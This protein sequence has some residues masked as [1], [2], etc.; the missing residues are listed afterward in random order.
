MAVLRL[1]RG[2][3]KTAKGWR[4]RIRV[5]GQ[6]RYEK[7]FPFSTP[8]EDVIQ[9]AIEARA[10][11]REG[12]T[13]DLLLPVGGTLAGDIARYL[14]DFYKSRP[15][16]AER[17][18]HLALW[19]DELGAETWRKGIRREAVSRVL[20][21]WRAAGL[22]PETCNKRRTALLAMFNALDGRSAK[23][24][25]RDVAKFRVPPPLARGLD[26]RL[27]ARAFRKMSRCPTRARLKV[28]AYTGARPVQVRRIVPADWDKRGRTLLLRATEK[29]RGTKHFR[30]P[31]THLGQAAMR[32]F[33]E[34]KAWGDFTSAPM[35]RMWKAAAKAAK[36]PADVVVYDLRHTFGTAA[37]R[38]S[39]D[40]RATQALLGQASSKMT[41]RYT[42]G[43]VAERMSAA[44]RAVDRA[45][46]KRKRA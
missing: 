45:Q 18:R 14:R 33:A 31:L 35:G 27:V 22:N 11:M 28:I 15:G 12:D 46:A 4:V 3:S 9:H 39:G 34:L 17:E 37:Y 7:R 40:I 10:K 30:I 42:Q 24:P 44:V 25:I 19:R 32:E 38:R 1:P 26:D 41:E 2:I 36:L 6:E 20:E 23:N 21:R 29:G 13:E 5:L 16:L 43:A 8:L